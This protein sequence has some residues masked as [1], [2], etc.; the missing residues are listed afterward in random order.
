MEV[1]RAKVIRVAVGGPDDDRQSARLSFGAGGAEILLIARLREEVMA[2]KQGGYFLARKKLRPLEALRERKGF[3]EALISRHEADPAYD[4]QTEVNPGAD[5]KGRGIQKEVKAFPGDDPP[6]PETSERSGGLFNG[7]G[8]GWFNG[9]VEHREIDWIRKAGNGARRDTVEGF[10]RPLRL[11]AAD[12]EPVACREIRQADRRK[13]QPGHG[14]ELDRLPAACQP[15]YFLK[16]GE[17]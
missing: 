16:T 17:E 2:M 4:G 8:F 9:Q 7:C 10:E 13:A 12:D 3:D 11:P 6:Q 5:R 14:G 15:G 1:S